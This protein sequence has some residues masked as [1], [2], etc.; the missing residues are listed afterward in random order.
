LLNGPSHILSPAFGFHNGYR[1]Q[2]DEQ[3]IVRRAIGRW[4]FGNRQVS[5]PHRSDASRVR[6]RQRVRFPAGLAK[7]LVDD[8][9]GLGLVEIQLLSFVLRQFGHCR[10][11]LSGCRCHLGLELG[12]VLLKLPSFVFELL[13]GFDG[14]FECRRQI[15]IRTLCS[16]LGRLTLP[17]MVFDQLLGPGHLLLRGD[18]RFA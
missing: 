17:S 18:Q 13:F 7:L 2:T 12:E 6:Q 8:P 5:P 15:V 10:S 4:P 1:G 14:S 11:L 3:H 16:G 9:T